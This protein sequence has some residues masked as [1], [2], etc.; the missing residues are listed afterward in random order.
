MLRLDKRKIFIYAA[1]MGLLVLLYFFGLLKPLENLAGK[2]L[3]PVLARVQSFSSSIRS[4]YNEQLSKADASEVLSEKQ[5]EIDRLLA[6]NAELKIQKDE[7]DILRKYLDYFSKNKHRRVLAAVIS[8]GDTFDQ[9]GRIEILG[10]DKGAKDGI[11]S[12]MAVINEEGIIIGKVAAVKQAVSEVELVLND[13][14]R[15]AATILGEDKTSGIVQGDLGLT[16]NMDFIPQSKIIKEGDIVISSGL[17]E[18]I[19]RGLVIGKVSKLSKENNEL[20]Q[21]AVL[22]SSVDFDK[23][24]IVSV[25]MP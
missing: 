21:S 25:L 4:K 2:G 6:E 5:A 7:N 19:P 11:R 10:I 20:W 13:D 23:V 9:A 22:E 1:V 12:G 14:C 15:L 17:E 3:N 18:S 8:R 16:M 24:V